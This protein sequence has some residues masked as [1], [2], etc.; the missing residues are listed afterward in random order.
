[1]R[2]DVVFDDPIV[3]LAVNTPA[4]MPTVEA[5][6]RRPKDEGQDKTDGSDY[7]QYDADGM[8][9]EVRRVDRCCEPE[10]RT[11][12]EHNDARTKTHL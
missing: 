8:N 3:R 11:Y 12:R 4:A 10:N 7:H 6:P 1:M 9:V 5:T 2:D